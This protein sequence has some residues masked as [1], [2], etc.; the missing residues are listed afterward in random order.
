MS[1]VWSLDLSYCQPVITHVRNNGIPW[2]D[3]LL[4]VGWLVDR[5]GTP[6]VNNHCI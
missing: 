2:M 3:G 5:G 1:H 4:D 6:R